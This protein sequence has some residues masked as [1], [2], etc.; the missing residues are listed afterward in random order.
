MSLQTAFI[1]EFD[2]N[3]LYRR[4]ISV[5]LLLAV[6]ST[7]SA[8]SSG[9]PST[10][11]PVLKASS[12]KLRA[13]SQVLAPISGAYLGAWANPAGGGPPT[14]SPTEL[15][16]ETATLEG[17]MVRPLALHMHY[18][19]WRRMTTLSTDS[20]IL[21]DVAHNRVPVVSWHCADDNESP[22]LTLRNV[23]TGLRPGVMRLELSLVG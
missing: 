8:C 3:R 1:Q 17:N 19:D 18:F 9:V 4:V 13:Q 10:V 2:E 6:M 21:D 12:A 14:P 11:S 16:Q 7:L 20:E 15:I 5:L 23:S 22:A